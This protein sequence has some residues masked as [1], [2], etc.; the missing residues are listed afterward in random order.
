MLTGQHFV[1]VACDWTTIAM[2]FDSVTFFV[3]WSMTQIANMSDSAT[4]LTQMSV[5]KP[6]V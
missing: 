3:R 5:T 4:R 1:S 6:T 2:E